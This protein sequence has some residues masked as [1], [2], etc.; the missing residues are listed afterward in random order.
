M[1]AF[2]YNGVKPNEMTEAVICACLAVELGKI[3]KDNVVDFYTRISLWEGAFGALTH[4][5][6]TL[7]DVEHHV[8]LSTNVQNRSWQ[9]FAAKLYQT[10]KLNAESLATAAA[11]ERRG[12]R[13]G[14]R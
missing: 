13:E 9:Q 10:Q 12:G 1:L 5:K 3:T 7:E 2:H 4:R 14:G 6:I 8:G 11:A